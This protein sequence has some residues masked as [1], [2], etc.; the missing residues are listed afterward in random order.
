[1]I[2]IDRFEN[3]FA[4]VENGDSMENIPVELI[5]SE[6][7]E[8]D[9]LIYENGAYQVDPGKTSELRSLASE[10]LSRLLKK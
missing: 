2:V 7:R 10:R 5:P 1:M 8:G 3:G 6:A 4:V 9:V